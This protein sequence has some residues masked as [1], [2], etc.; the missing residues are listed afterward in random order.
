M[1]VACSDCNHHFLLTANGIVAGAACPNCGGKRLERDQPSPLHSDGELRN[2]VDPDTGMDQGGNPLMEGIWGSI[3]NGWRPRGVRDESFASVK[4]AYSDADAFVQCDQ[5]HT[6]WGEAG[7]AGLMLAHHGDD[8]QTRYLLQHR[9]PYVDHPNTWSTPGGALEHGETPEAGAVR[10][11]EEEMGQLPPHTIT[12]VQSDDHGGWAYHTVHGQVAGQFDPRRDML[13][14]AYGTPEGQDHGWFTPEEIDQLPLHPGFAG[15]WQR[16]RHMYSKTAAQPIGTMMCPQCQASGEFRGGICPMCEGHGYT[17]A[18]RGADGP[19]YNMHDQSPLGGEGIV[20]RGPT[21]NDPSDINTIPYSID[22]KSLRGRLPL[23]RNVGHT[24]D[25]TLNM[26]PYP[27]LWSDDF[28]DLM[29]KEAAAAILPALGVAA[30]WALPKALPYLMRGALMGTGSNIVQGLLGGGGD[31]GGGAGEQIAPPRPDTVFSHTAAGIGDMRGD[32]YAL[33]SGG[34]GQFYSCPNCGGQ[35][36]TE[37]GECYRCGYTYGYD[38]GEVLDGHSSPHAWARDMQVPSFNG[39]WGPRHQGHTAG[40]SDISSGDLSNPG[41]WQHDNAA[42]ADQQ[43][44]ADESTDPAFQNPNADAGGGEGGVTTDNP[45]NAGHGTDPAGI[46]ADK[47]TFQA[48][49]PGVQRAEMLLPLLMDYHNSPDSGANEP[50]IRELHELLEKENPGYLNNVGNEHAHYWEELRSHL[51]EPSAIQAKTGAG[52][53]DQLRTR[54]QGQYPQFDDQGRNVTPMVDQYNPHP[55]NVQNDPMVAPTALPAMPASQYEPMVRQQPT[56]PAMQHADIALQNEKFRQPLGNPIHA[57]DKVAQGF[58][59]GM[60]MVPGLGNGMA[61]AVQ[62]GGGLPGVGQQGQCPYCGGTQQADGSCPQC[63]AKAP[64]QGMQQAMPQTNSAPPGM[65]PPGVAPSTTVAPRMGANEHTSAL[66]ELVQMAIAAGLTPAAFATMYKALGP[67]IDALD[68]RWTPDDQMINRAQDPRA[69]NPTP[70]GDRL[71]AVQ[72]A[73]NIAKRCPNCGSGTTGIHDDWSGQAH[74][75][76]CGTVFDQE[77]AQRARWA[78]VA[79]EPEPM[80][81]DQAPPVG[82]PA[83]DQN[84]AYDPEQDQDSSLTWQD[85]NGQ[86]LVPGSQYEMHSEQYA[87]PDIIRVEQDKPDELVFTTIG[88]QSPVPTADSGDQPLERQH[89]LRKQDA[90]M[91]G[92]TFVPVDGN[93]S[94]AGEQNLDEYADQGQA[95]VFT[96]PVKSSFQRFAPLSE[97]DKY[98]GGES[99][100][101]AKAKAAM[102]KKYGEEKGEQVF[103]ALVNKRKK[104]HSAQEVDD[105]WL[106]ADVGDELDGATVIDV[107][108]M[109]HHLDDGRILPGDEVDALLRYEAGER[110]AGDN[111]GPQTPEQIS[112]VQKLLVDMGRVGEVHNVPL[113]PWNYVREMAQVAQK[114]NVA[115]QMPPGQAPTPPPMDPSMMGGPPPGGAPPDPGMMMQGS[116][117]F[118]GSC[119]ACNSLHV[120]S[121]M[122]SPND[123][124]HEC[125]QCGELWISRTADVGGQGSVKLAWLYEDP[126]DDFAANMER[127]AAMRHADSG[128][129]NIKDIAAKDARLQAI[130]QRLASNPALFKHGGANFTS[131]EQREFINES[132]TARNSDLLDLEDTHYKLKDEWETKGNAGNAPDEHLLFGM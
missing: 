25:R 92:V 22:P 41:Y 8:G 98:F 78:R 69:L 86:K 5:G 60:G 44:F 75:H 21:E 73:D 53:L 49:S 14:P 68:R 62:P 126:T 95:P 102:I 30:R 93:D 128:S 11:T 124:E 40:E 6:H 58:A 100:A 85:S 125:Y 107:D 65:A 12:H 127:M 43:Q 103:Y 59:P 64:P 35:M 2:M 1:N 37:T 82:V 117:E 38:G 33:P 101:A 26:E 46:G 29:E 81:Q 47:P 23:V 87:V 19:Y 42:D 109:T 114:V 20:I 32:E 34:H 89:R 66:S 45:G 88:E 74:C 67:P 63:G 111:Q 110:H 27:S 116:T 120:T 15:S 90:D 24:M 79:A 70:E 84:E 3:D 56:N 10:E 54:M 7:A 99:G 16:N 112:A 130:K 76:A 106:V 108:N 105:G 118:D 97:Y 131:Q 91:Y 61:P 36:N 17:F 50:L 48:D 94:N 28:A 123:T 132:G 55:M 104:K 57:S 18:D 39:D 52:L 4:H 83:A 129:R 13:D 51:R 96:E 121:S 9:S 122:I 80:G 71:P 31:Q 113:E 119:R 115:P 72:G 77:G